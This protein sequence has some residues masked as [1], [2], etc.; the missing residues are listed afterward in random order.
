MQKVAVNEF[1]R[2][3][4]KGFGKT[5]SPDLSYEEIASHAEVQMASGKFKEGYREGIRIV[6][7]SKNIAK[8][9]ICVTARY[10]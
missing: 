1:V 5:Y 8:K 7:G 2:R 9:F 4:I 3:Q 10:N 6:S